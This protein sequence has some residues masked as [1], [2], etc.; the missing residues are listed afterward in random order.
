MTIHE[1]PFSQYDGETKTLWKLGLLKDQGVLEASWQDIAD[2]LNRVYRTDESEYRTEAAYRKPYQYA[3]MF[4]GVIEPAGNCSNPVTESIKEERIALQKERC[5]LRDERTQYNKYIRDESRF[6]QRLDSLETL[7]RENADG[8]YAF[9]QRAPLYNTTYSGKSEMLL[10]LSDWHIGLEFRNEFGCYNSE[11][12]QKRLDHLLEEVLRIK[13]RHEC[14]NINVVALGDMISGA[15]RQTIQVANRE[16]VIEQVVK[17]SEMM[18]DFLA[19]LCYAFDE[20][21]FMSIAGNHSRIEASKEKACKDDRLDDLIG[22]YVKAALSKA[23]N[24][25]PRMVVDN[26]VSELAI[27]GNL[28]YFVHG[29]HDVN[30][31]AGISKLAFMLGEIPYAVCTA[32]R[33]FPMMTEVNGVKVIQNGSL[34]GSGDD[35]TVEMRLSGKPSQTIAVCS[36]NGIDCYYPV[37]LDV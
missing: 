7:I 34:C 14:K 36:E 22:W 37:Q 27:C 25:K 28:F 11:L 23:P 21:N 20:V 12:A 19:T 29:D 18:A 31:Q 13:D 9:D 15:I 6:E 32:H 4:V 5:R 2:F 17:A 24:F 8:R 16:N 30:T 1:Y 35:H 26:T 33:H 3:K 10:L